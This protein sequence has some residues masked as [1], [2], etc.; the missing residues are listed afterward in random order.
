MGKDRFLIFDMDGVLINSE[1]FHKEVLEAVFRSQGLPMT[2]A[3]YN[4]LVGMSNRAIWEKAVKD[5]G[6]KQS[7]DNLMNYHMEVFFEMLE[8]RTIPQPEGMPEF[9]ERV[10]NSDIRCS[11]ASSS[12]VK[13]INEFVRRLQI[14]SLLDHKVSGEDLPRSKPF[15][16]IFLRVSALYGADPADFWVIE[17]SAH[18]VKAALAAGMQCIGYRNPDSGNQDLSAAHIEIDHFD[19]LNE[20]LL[21]KL[22]S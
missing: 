1:P 15:P 17:D 20:K 21:R 5:H 12:P 3:Y 4:S 19:E 14:D 2:G 18:G 16:D 6:L 11:L 22:W 13:L 8:S 7:T 10:R 9:L